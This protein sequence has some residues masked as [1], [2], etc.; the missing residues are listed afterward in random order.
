M[1]DC[2][3]ILHSTPVHFL[4]LRCCFYMQT[5]IKYSITIVFSLFRSSSAEPTIAT[6]T[7][8]ARNRTTMLLNHKY[9]VF[10]WHASEFSQRIGVSSTFNSSLFRNCQSLDVKRKSSS[11][12]RRR[13][14]AFRCS[15]WFS[16]W[17]R[18]ST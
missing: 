14:T 13:S 2:F 16:S 15:L 4:S 11:A 8:F 6:H 12:R 3:N 5:L 9:I 1:T 10:W 7:Q 17:W 18:E